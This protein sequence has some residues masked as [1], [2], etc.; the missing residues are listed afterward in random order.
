MP[1]ICSHGA[2]D[3]Y[4]GGNAFLLIGCW[5]RG[6]VQPVQMVSTKNLADLEFPEASAVLWVSNCTQA[7]LGKAGGCGL[8]EALRPVTHGGR[9]SVS[10]HLS[11]QSIT[12]L[13]AVDPTHQPMDSVTR[14][15]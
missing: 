12:P 2:L 6:Q 10:K 9:E 8:P 11:H 7:A 4:H 15:P 3:A 5:G 1:A 13:Y 14:L